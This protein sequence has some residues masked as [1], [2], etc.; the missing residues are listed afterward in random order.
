LSL[1]AGAAAPL[2]W[3]VVALKLGDVVVRDALDRPSFL[4]LLQ[5]LAQNLRVRVHAV[6]ESIAEE[7][8]SGLSGAILLGS[9]LLL[10]GQPLSM[11]VAG[12][13]ALIAITAVAWLSL[14]ARIRPAYDAMLGRALRRRTLAVSESEPFA[15]ESSIAPFLRSRLASEDPGEVIYCLSLV[16]PR[17]DRGELAGHLRILLR[18]AEPTVR[19]EACRRVE[20]ARLASL[21]ST[22]DEALA[23]ERSSGG[24]RVGRHPC[25]RA[26]RH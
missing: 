18:H 10:A 12:A 7:M 8:T 11:K 23:V 3:P 26:P 16:A 9:T 22:L 13:A 2:F 15:W 20:K 21:R 4:V 25:D 14:V 24:G 17:L 1:T 5:V 19:L 6:Q